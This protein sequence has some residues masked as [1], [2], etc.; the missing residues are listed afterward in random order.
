MDAASPVLEPPVFARL[1]DLVHRETGIWLADHK[2]AMLASRLCP[3][4]R[5]LGMRSF[6]DYCGLLARGDPEGAE[7]RAAINCVTTNHTE[8]FRESDHFTFL[9]DR[10]RKRP[11]NWRVWC[12][13][14]STGEE[15]YT[16]AMTLASAG[17]ANWRVFATDIDTGVLAAAA[18]GVYPIEALARLPQGFRETYFLRGTGE[19]AGKA[20]VRRE[21]RSRVEFR[22]LNLVGS[23]WPAGD[24]YDAIFCRNVLI[25]FNRDTQR[26]VV[27]RLLERL[28]RGGY[29]FL[30]HSENLNGMSSEVA[31]RAHT[32]Y[33]RG[34]DVGR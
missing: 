15:P 14:S 18:R 11:A 23:V 10:V 31:M 28:R 3:R 21:V 22:R 8:F 12:A 17:A 7:L 2:R 13:A 4:L 16:I 25:Y 5:D 1:R 33:Q 27:G 24:G 20:K 19:W 32:V 30:G 6:A 26:R 34:K 29:L 9:A